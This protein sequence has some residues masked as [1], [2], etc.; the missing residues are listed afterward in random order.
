MERTFQSEDLALS[1]A[2][3]VGL[4]EWLC[5]GCYTQCSGGGGGAGCRV[6]RNGEAGKGCA[7]AGP[8]CSE[9]IENT[10]EF[11]FIF[12]AAGS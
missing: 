11:V 10:P 7:Y 6:E 12:H 2:Q 3:D 4:K 1:E 9:G 8:L 5:S